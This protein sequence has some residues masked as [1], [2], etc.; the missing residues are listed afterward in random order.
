MILDKMIFS[1]QIVISGQKHIILNKNNDLYRKSC[2]GQEN[3]NSYYKIGT[4]IRNNSNNSNN[5]NNR[6]N[7]NHSNNR[8]NNS[9]NSNNSN[10]NSNNSM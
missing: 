5:S 9:K 7:S 10:N 8:N 1:L 2:C 6:N 3:H 4:N